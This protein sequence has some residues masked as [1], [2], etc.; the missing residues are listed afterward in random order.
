[1]ESA[2]RFSMKFLELIYHRL[3]ELDV[4]IKNGHMDTDLA[5]ELLVIELTG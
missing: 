5:L 4:A 3:L 2:P 1:M